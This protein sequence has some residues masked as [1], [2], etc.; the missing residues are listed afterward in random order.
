MR[1][2]KHPHSTSADARAMSRR[3]V[4]GFTL[5]VFVER[6]VEAQGG[7]ASQKPTCDVP[8]KVGEVPL[9]LAKE[10]DWR[11]EN[12]PIHCSPTEYKTSYF[13]PGN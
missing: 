4:G 11:A 2:E 9:A 7:V 1:G 6:K 12:S 10:I 3:R 5:N 8:I 13:C